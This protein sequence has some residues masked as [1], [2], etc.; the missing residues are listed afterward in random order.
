MEEIEG[1]EILSGIE[2]LE[3]DHTSQTPTLD[4][5]KVLTLKMLVEALVTNRGVMYGHRKLMNGAAIQATG[6]R[7]LLLEEVGP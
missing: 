5:V 2:V 6:F 4:G 3:G 1:E 7:I